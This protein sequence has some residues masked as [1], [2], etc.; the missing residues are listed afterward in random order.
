MTYLIIFILWM[1]TNEILGHLIDRQSVHL[2]IVH[3]SQAFGW[4][5]L[6]LLLVPPVVTI[7]IIKG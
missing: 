1:I 7:A 5:F 6:L 2:L 4:P 3:A